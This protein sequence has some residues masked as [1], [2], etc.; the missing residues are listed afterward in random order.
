MPPE[1]MLKQQARLVAATVF[2]L[3]LALVALAF[4]VA[5]GVRD[6]GLPWLGL[7]AERPVLRACG[8]TAHAGRPIAGG[9]PASTCCD[10]SERIS[11]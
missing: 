1:S 5:H 11:V 10:A 9:S 7:S 2:V 6:R 3:D 8:I 4:L